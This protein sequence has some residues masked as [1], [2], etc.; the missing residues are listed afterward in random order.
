M[1]AAWGEAA[2]MTVIYMS[3]A[4][5]GMHNVLFNAMAEHDRF[6]GGAK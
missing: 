3:N 2:G 6:T 4:V 1:F 5:A